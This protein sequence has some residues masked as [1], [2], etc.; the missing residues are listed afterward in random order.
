MMVPMIPERR[1]VH[2]RYLIS[3]QV[4]IPIRTFSCL[5]YPS[6]CPP[7]RPLST[8]SK[9][10]LMAKRPMTAGMKVIP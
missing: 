4:G 10:S 6:R 5:L 2:F 8:S 1:K 7:F 9:T 3:S